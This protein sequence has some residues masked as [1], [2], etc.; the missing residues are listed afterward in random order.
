MG[1]GFGVIISISY[2]DD[3][4]FVESL[5]MEQF[6]LAFAVQAGGLTL[7]PPAGFS[8]ASSLCAHREQTSLAI[9]VNGMSASLGF[10]V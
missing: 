2:A 9:A 6:V 8:A 1:S 3:D 4:G 10:R 5:L 7:H